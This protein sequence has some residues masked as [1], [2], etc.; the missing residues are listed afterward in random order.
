MNG[1]EGEPHPAYPVVMGTPRYPR[2]PV[3]PSP[4]HPDRLR[5]NARYREQA[6]VLTPH[7][8]VA[9]S[10]AAGV[11]DGPVL[12]LAC[13]RSGSALAFAATGRAVLAVDAS[14]VA[15]EQLGQEAQQRGLAD[16]IDCVLGDV[17]ASESLPSGFAVVLA[18]RFWDSVAFRAACSAVATGGL[19]GWEALAAES[20]RRWHIRHGALGAS[21]P[22]GF[23]ILDERLYE[24][25]ARCCSRLLARKLSG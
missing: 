14:D 5:W 13:G 20:A 12:E 6:P 21:L 11:P 9:A 2:I 16:R 8:L 24:Q 25:G 3:T 22:D 19:L 7:P 17:T 18:T 4:D 23:R 10:L 1:G 15:L